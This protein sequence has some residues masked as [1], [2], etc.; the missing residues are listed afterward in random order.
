[1]VAQ[2]NI[3]GMLQN[4]IFAHK[5]KLNH[6]GLLGKLFGGS[7]G[8]AAGTIVGLGAK[9]WAGKKAGN[10][11]NKNISMFKDTINKYQ[12]QQTAD[13]AHTDAV[14]NEDASSNVN[15][16]AAVTAAN[17]INQQ[18]NEQAR[19]Q[20]ILTGGSDESAALAKAQGAQT[21][22]GMLSSAAVQNQ[23]RQDN[24]YEQGQQN[25]MAYQQATDAVQNKLA[26]QR[27]AKARGIQKTG[28]DFAQASAEI[29][30]SLKI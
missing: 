8:S 3:I 24:A 10:L 22:G 18:N 26:A 11:M 1:V 9:L 20:Q 16:M 30:N 2:N 25:W 15:T 13:K 12:A 21:V 19:A 28:N 7:Y 5:I 29:G 23:T 4:P 14:V 17:N 27:E 6:M